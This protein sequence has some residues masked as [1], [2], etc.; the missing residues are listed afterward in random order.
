MVVGLRRQCFRTRPSA[1]AGLIKGCWILDNAS[2]PCSRAAACA[3]VCMHVCMYVPFLGRAGALSLCT[4]RLLLFV[5]SNGRRPFAVQRR[6][7]TRNTLCKPQVSQTSL[8]Q[9]CAA[10]EFPGTYGFSSRVPPAWL[11]SARRCPFARR[12]PWAARAYRVHPG[13][14]PWSREASRPDSRWRGAV[15]IVRR[16]K[17]RG[18]RSRGIVVALRRGE[19]QALRLACPSLPPPFKLPP[20]AGAPTLPAPVPPGDNE[21]THASHYAGSLAIFDSF[22]PH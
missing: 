4:I 7:F 12:R 8:R 1:R 5:H 20:L 11:S 17:C 22:L 9:Y 13:P 3:H 15:E 18:V 19:R 21:C 16:W 6:N 10:A 2:Q 14:S